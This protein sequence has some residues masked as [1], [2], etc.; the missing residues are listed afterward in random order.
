ML[1]T[2]VRDIFLTYVPE[3]ACSVLDWSV[4]PRLRAADSLA[5]RRAKGGAQRPQCLSP[6]EQ[7][8]SFFPGRSRCRVTISGASGLCELLLLHERNMI[9]RRG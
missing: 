1:Y 9:R 6:E 2:F 7:D 4:M 5:L 3:V 8:E